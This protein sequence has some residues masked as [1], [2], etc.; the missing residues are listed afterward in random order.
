MHGLHLIADL[1]QCA[2][3]HDLMSDAATLADLCR[4]GTRDA[5]LTLVGEKWHR[6]PAHQGQAGGVTSTLLLAESHVAVHTWPELAGVPLDAYVC[7]FPATTPARPSVWCRGSWRRSNPDVRR[8]NGCD[9][10]TR[11]LK[12][13]TG[14][15]NCC[16]KRSMPT[17]RMAFGLPAAIAHPLPRRALVV[18]GGDGGS[19]EERLKHPSIERRRD[20]FASGAAVPR[21]RSGARNGRGIGCRIRAR[22]VLWLACPALWRVMGL[23]RGFRQAMAGSARSR[24]SAAALAGAENRRTALLQRGDT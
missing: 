19:V 6:F 23:C 2:C 11:R 12:A 18:G 9:A 13:R 7:N 21:P 3:G 8:C 4:I 15:A 14:R 1:F 24:A 16:S 17:V 5:G 10:A 22:P 20:D